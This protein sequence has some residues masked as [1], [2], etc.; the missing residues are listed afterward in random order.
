MDLDEG[1]SS[2]GNGER[3]GVVPGSLK[4]QAVTGD[5]RA[6][7]VRE[8]GCLHVVRSIERIA[9]QMT[10]IVLQKATEWPVDSQARREVLRRGHTATAQH[11]R[12]HAEAEQAGEQIPAFAT[13]IWHFW[14]SLCIGRLD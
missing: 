3:A 9:F 13:V 8:V 1:G 7:H 4:R 5:A 6:G 2:G 10:I 14:R 12:K 11:R